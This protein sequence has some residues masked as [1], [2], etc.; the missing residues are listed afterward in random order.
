[1]RSIRRTLRAGL[2][3]ELTAAVEHER[4]EQLRLMETDDFRE[5]IRASLDR[6]QPRFSGR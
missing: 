1:V 2:V 3:G 5:G 6:R 4:V